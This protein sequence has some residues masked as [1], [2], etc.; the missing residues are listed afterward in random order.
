MLEFKDSERVQAAH[1]DQVAA[2]ARDLSEYHGGS[3]D[4]LV[5][6]VLVLTRLGGTATTLRPSSGE[7]RTVRDLREVL[8]SPFDVT[9]TGPGGLGEVLVSLEARS[10]AEAIDAE[11]WM[12]ADYEPLPSLVKAARLLFNH[13]PLPHIRR[14]ES[15]GVYD[16]VAYLDGVAKEARGSN[17]RHVA[18]V[19]GVPGSGKTLVGLQFVYQNHFEQRDGA[20]SAVFLSGNGPLVDVLQY[21]L[22]NKIFVQDVHGFLKQYGGRSGRTPAERI[23]VYDEAQRAWDAERVRQKRGLGISEP[24]DFLR[25]GAR[26]G[27]WAL[28]VGLIGEGQE[29]HLGEEAGLSQWND[30]LARMSEPWVVHCPRHVAHF[31]PAAARLQVADVLDLTVSL[32]SHRAEDVQLWVG[33]VLHGQL[34]EAGR[35]APALL[36]SGFDLYV[37]RDLEA[38]KLYARERYRGGEDT[39]FGLL[40]SSKGKLERYGIDG[41]Y[42]ATRRL[43]VG[44]WFWD[45]P[46]APLSCCQLRAVATE[47][48]C[49]GLELDFPLVAWGTDVWWDGQ[50]W[51]SRPQPRSEAKDAHQLRIN[52]YRVLLTRGRDG[53]A[54]FVPSG[55][56]SA[57]ATFAALREAGA[58][59]ME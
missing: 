55:S 20:R 27:S 6:P 17:E 57:D 13:E 1:V 56:G 59:L 22:K 29:I 34:D 3:H 46:D 12:Q 15:A 14:C 35:R 53:V 18:L 47:F 49:Q 50:A 48:Q 36:D 23:W 4:K 44:P 38:A 11:A 37:T 10:P 30:A 16:T 5:D 26:A 24:E 21:A 58:E 25:I 7:A 9:I 33:D 41:G 52:S 8:P 39:R 54:M 19:T 51:K 2:Y 45:S 43:K 31:F 28:M 40:S 32:R 42:Q